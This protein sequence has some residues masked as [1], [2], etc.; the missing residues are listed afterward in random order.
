MGPLRF[1]EGGQSGAS[2]VTRA[3]AGHTVV[4][5]ASGPSLTT[6]QVQRTQAR[7]CA[8]GRPVA[9]IVVNDN[10]QAAPWADVLYFADRKWHE[11]NKEKPEFQAFAGQKCTIEAG[12]WMKKVPAG[13]HALGMNG[14]DGLSLQA[15]AIRTGRN[16]GHQAINI[17]FLAGAAQILL[18]GY[19]G[20]RAED[21]KQHHFGEHPDKSEPPYA[22]MLQHMKTIP[23]F[24]KG[25]DIVNC[26]PGSAIECFRTGDITNFLVTA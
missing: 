11:W 23:A 22:Q 17:A 21:G 13:I 24:A 14:G 6:E 26:S 12:G 15:N 7:T 5:I 19:D 20:K 8:A 2:E 3:W 1:I 9:V 16:S 10:Y 18:I 25:V 4:C